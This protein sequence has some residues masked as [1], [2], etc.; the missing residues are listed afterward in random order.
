M[1]RKTLSI[2]STLAL[3]VAHG[4]FEATVHGSEPPRVE[5]LSVATDGQTG[6]GPSGSDPSSPMPP[7]NKISADGRYVVFERFAGNLIC[8]DTNFSSQDI[9]VRDRLTG[10]TTLVSVA[11]DGAQGNTNSYDPAISADG[12]YVAFSSAATSLV[13]GD[14]NGYHD[15]FVPDLQA[16]T[17]TRVSVSTAGDQADSVAQGPAISGDGRYIAFYSNATNLVAG[18][19]NN[20]WDVLRLLGRRGALQWPTEA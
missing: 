13:P 20:T 10:T 9:F 18:D 1:A 2:L 14:T 17:T 11:W 12:R 6:N 3:L 7:R 16:G 8:S 15:V 19:V 4:G 5:L